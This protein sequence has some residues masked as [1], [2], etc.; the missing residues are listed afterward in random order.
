MENIVLNAEKRVATEKVAYLRA[1]KSVPGVVYGRKQENIS[2]KMNA[3]DL[4]RVHRKAWESHI[5]ELHIEGE[6]IDVLIHEVQKEPVSGDIIHI[7]FYAFVRW[8]KV[9]AKITID[10]VWSSQAVK[11]WAILNENVKEIEVTCLPRDLV[12]SFEVDLS[13]LKKSEDV[14]RLS[15]LNIDTE[16][17]EV[18]H[19]HPEE[20]IAIAA[21]AKVE[22]EPEDNTE[23]ATEE[24]SENEEK[25]DTPPA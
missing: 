19:L 6:T 1:N 22:V 13:L 2:L 25:S 17:Y 7:D 4:L 16:K 3:S 24:S 9:T 12:D 18:L 14:I 21:K 10:F 20:A 8:E 23:T 11:E 5:V 15:D